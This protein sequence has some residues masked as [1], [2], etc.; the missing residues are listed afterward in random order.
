MIC[1]GI[2]SLS[3]I[4]GFFVKFIPLSIFS[5]FKVNEE[6]LTN[7]YQRQES[8]RRSFRKSRSLYKSRTKKVKTLASS[9]II[10][11]GMENTGI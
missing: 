4:V 11:I 8:Y 1:V 5:Y 6:P 3:I 2:G 10:N 7:E 9:G